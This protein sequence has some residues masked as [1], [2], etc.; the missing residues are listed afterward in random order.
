MKLTSVNIQNQD[1]LVPLQMIFRSLKNLV[2]RL[3]GLCQFSLFQRPNAKQQAGILLILLKMKQNA[4]KCL[5]VIMRFQISQK[6]TQN[7]GQLM[8]FAI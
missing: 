2:L 1:H 4:T 8:I 5:E 3:Y 6:S 7:L